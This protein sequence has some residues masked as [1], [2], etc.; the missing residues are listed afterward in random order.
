MAY[1]EL[2]IDQ[3]TTFETSVSLT[4]DD[5]TA[6]NITNYGFASQIR[7]SYYS[8]NP[9]ANL[10]VTIADAA[11]GNVKLSMTA[12]NTANVRAGRY[13]YD[14]IMTDTG[15]VKTRVIEGIITVTPQVTR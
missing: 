12:A 15:G 3:G 7:K 13:L 8:T 6:I 5:Q 1:V 4:N 14:L 11:T 9:V 2:T 10:T